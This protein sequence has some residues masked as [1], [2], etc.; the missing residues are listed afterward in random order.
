M[1]TSKLK[2]FAQDARRTLREQVE[3]KL[4]QVLAAESSARRESPAAV[5]R[6]ADRGPH[7]D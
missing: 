3:A 5:E 1:D 2:T 7:P 4:S 6:L